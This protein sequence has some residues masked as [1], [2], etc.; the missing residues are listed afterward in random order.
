M[1]PET[2][3]YFPLIMEGSTSSSLS[4]LASSNITR[5]KIPSCNG[6]TALHV[7]GS[8]IITGKIFL[9]NSTSDPIISLKV[10]I[11]PYFAFFLRLYSIF[12]LSSFPIEPSALL[13]VSC[14][15]FFIWYF[16][17]SVMN[18]SCSSSFSILTE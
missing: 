13:L 2:I 11:F 15:F 16:W 5:S 10:F 12:M 1:S 17:F 9:K 3:L 4:W 8:V 6:N 7:L 18:L 14:Q